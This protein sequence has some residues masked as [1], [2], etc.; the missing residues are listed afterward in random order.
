VQRKLAGF[1]MTERGIARHGYAMYDAEGAE[2][3]RV[4]S[5]GPAPTLEKNVGMGYVPVGL[6]VPGTKLSIDCRGKRV[7]AEVV[8]GPFYKRQKRG[9][10]S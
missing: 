5:G 9:Q 8:S 1:V 6:D 7:D 3:G 4:T 2:V 10:S